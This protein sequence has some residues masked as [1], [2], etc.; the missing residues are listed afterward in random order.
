GQAPPS[1]GVSLRTINRNFKGRSGTPDAK[2]YLVS[3]ET[4][5]ASAVSGVITDPRELGAPPKIKLPAKM[6][7]DDSMIIE[8]SDTP[9]EVEIIRGPGI[10]PCPLN[11]PLE[12]KI[13]AEVLLKV[14][15]DISTDDILPGGADV[16]PL[17]SDIPAISA[18]VFRDLDP[19]FAER[20]RKTGGGFIV[21]GANYG[22]GSSREHAAI[23][24]MSL[25]VK[26]VIAKSFARIHRANLIN[27]GILPLIFVHPADYDRISQGDRLTIDNADSSAIEPGSQS[28][29]KNAAGALEFS[30]VNDLSERES[31]IMAAGGLLNLVR[32]QAQR[33]Q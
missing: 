15:D 27:F 26:A 22:Q 30:V 18:H 5:A 29:V 16:L 25:G 6:F 28:V 4:A 23:A 33:T 20:A 9:D 13:E 3:T 2:V 7:T 19:E 31:D 10:K 11:Q 12:E 14:G 24:P 17:R 1:G 21:A 8:P 32:N